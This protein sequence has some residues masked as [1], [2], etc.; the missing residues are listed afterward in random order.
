MKYAVAIDIGGTNTRVALIDEE[1]NIV[2]R[3][4]FST[5]NKEPEITL[6]KISDIV[7]AFDKDIT[8]IGMSCPGP[9]DLINGKVLTP[10][11]LNGKWHNL[12]I[13]KVLSEKTGKPVYLDNDANLAGLAEAV[14]GEGKRLDDDGTLAVDHRCLVLPLGNVDPNDVHSI[15]SSRVQITDIPRA[16]EGHN[17]LRD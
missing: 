1:L 11:N 9:L 7:K 6:N 12:E 3:E 15:G 8:G 17:L 5:D 2:S 10:P 16:A 14:V 13:S 4:Q